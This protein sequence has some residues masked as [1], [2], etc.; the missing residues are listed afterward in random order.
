MTRRAAPDY[1]HRWLANAERLGVPNAVTAAIASD[2]GITA[3]GFRVLEKLTEITD[4]HGKSYFLLTP[5]TTG[6]DARVATLM[7]YVLNAGTG[8]GRRTGQPTDFPETPYGPDEVR[9]IVDRQAA[10]R[11]S[12]DEDVGFVDRHGGRLVTTPNGML[13]GVGGD[14]VQRLFSQQGGTAWGDIFLVN[15]PVDGDA[16]GRLRQIVESG[17]AWYTD[18]TGRARQGT[19]ALERVLHHEELHS[20]QW[21]ARGH[22][23]MITA[24]LWEVLRDRVFGKTNRLECQAGLADGG[25]R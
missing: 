5:G 9:R 20:Q 10:N 4:P 15:V 6:A 16:A 25:Y 14:W 1:H 11:W 19:L 2:H 7:T 12:Y 18:R 8:Y 17:H 23:R 24:Y 13:M 3:H 21:A 22:A